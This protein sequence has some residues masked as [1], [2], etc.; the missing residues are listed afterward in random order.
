MHTPP[1]PTGPAAPNWVR[2]STAGPQPGAPAGAGG[3]PAR[4]DAPPIA[5]PPEPSA[6]AEPVL[7][8][9]P[10]APAGPFWVGPRMP[11]AAPPGPTLRSPDGR[12]V[13]TDTTLTV[14]GETFLLR[15]LER[16]DLTPVRWLLWY[17]LGALGLAAVLIAFLQNWL[18]TGPAMLGMAATAL[19]L[20]YGHRGTNRLRLY[21]LGCE[22]LN[23]AL[24]GDADAWRR[25]S[26]EANRRIQCLHDQAAAEAAAYLAA[27]DEA[28]R[29]AAEA[30]RAADTGT[31]P[32][33]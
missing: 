13:L 30:A 33:A 31:L 23:F 32:A 25:L 22:A 12:V 6:A 14:R 24:P 18:R 15:E 19:L 10:T 2:S 11:E 20:A 16:T 29:L 21:R 4:P 26:Q 8:A 7:P 3:V 1:T 28:Q 17:L 5:A 9:P 27:A